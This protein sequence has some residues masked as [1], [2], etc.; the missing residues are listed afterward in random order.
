MVLVG[1]YKES[2]GDS[3]FEGRAGYRLEDDHVENG[4]DWVAQ[5]ADVIVAYEFRDEGLQLDTA[6]VLLHSL[7]VTS[8]Q[9]NGGPILISGEYFVLIE[10]VWVSKSCMFGALALI[11]G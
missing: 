7:F 8:R 5:V 11:L 9:E 10:Q 2:V 6:C 4:V 1:W 3:R